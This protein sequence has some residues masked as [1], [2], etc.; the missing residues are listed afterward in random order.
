MY[1]FSYYSCSVP[2][3][4][5]VPQAPAFDFA[6]KYVY[7]ASRRIQH[8]RRRVQVC[9]WGPDNQGMC[10]CVTFASGHDWLWHV[11]PSRLHD[12]S[13][14]QSRASAPWPTTGA[15]SVSIFLPDGSTACL[16]TP[17]L[18]VCFLHASRY[19]D[20]KLHTHTHRNT[21]THRH[22]DIHTYTHI[23]IYANDPLR[24]L[25]VCLLQMFR[26]LVSGGDH[27][28]LLSDELPEVR[29]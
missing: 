2:V 20:H 5:H 28:L 22:T 8:L 18:F 24:P 21:Q 19:S 25:V 16:P 10:C 4:R 29:P 26:Y 15:W 3:V 7:C 13:H 17:K 14:V 11:W 6:S 12:C 1:G 9:L 27:A 23:H